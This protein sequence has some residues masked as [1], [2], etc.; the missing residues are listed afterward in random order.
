MEN[1]DALGRLTAL[2]KLIGILEEACSGRRWDRSYHSWNCL[3]PPRSARSHSDGSSRRIQSGGSNTGTMVLQG[4][5]NE[6]WVFS[7]GTATG[8]VISGVDDTEGVRR[9]GG[10]QY[11]ILRRGTQL[12]LS[13]GTAS[14]AVLGSGAQLLVS[15]GGLAAGTT[16]P[17]NASAVINTGGTASG[18]M[19]LVV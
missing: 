16:F 10:I 18:T 2:M 13:G 1:V 11:H 3:R 5:H 4:F 7:G 19:V 12:F 8:T 6:Q 15:S 17:S 9:R 14:G